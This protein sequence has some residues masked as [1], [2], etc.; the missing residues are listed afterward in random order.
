ML[1]IGEAMVKACRFT[2]PV[3][4]QPAELTMLS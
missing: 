1:F 3:S 2:V 4:G